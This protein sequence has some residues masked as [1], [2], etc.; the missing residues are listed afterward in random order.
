[1]K[2]GDMVRYKIKESSFWAGIVVEVFVPDWEVN[3]SIDYVK[4]IWNQDPTCHG[5]I[6]A[7]LMEVVSESR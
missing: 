1:M 6:R 3:K 7:S 2:V 4:I 5:L